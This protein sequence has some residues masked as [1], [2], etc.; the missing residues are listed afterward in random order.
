MYLGREVLGAK[1]A[2]VYAMPRMMD[3]LK[4]NG[5]WSQLVSLNNIDIFPLQADTSYSLSKHLQVTPILV[6][7]RDEFSETVGFIIQAGSRRV[8]FIPDIDKWEKWDRNIEELV[9]TVDFAFLDATFFQDG[10][11]PG[12]SMAEVPH[13]FVEETMSRFESSSLETKKKIHFIHF[14]HTNPLMW[15]ESVRKEVNQ[16]GFNVAV[17]GMRIDLGL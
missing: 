4:T 14:N 15:D 11:L 1:G 12:R 7:H 9:E 8:L 17:E 6:P 16:K 13:P 10:E 2:P 3:F 5:P